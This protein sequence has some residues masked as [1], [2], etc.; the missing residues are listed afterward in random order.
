MNRDRRVARTRA[1]LIAAFDHLV[2]SRRG[3][4][5]RV[6]DIVE[7]ANVGR[8]TF[9]DHYSSADD[10]HMAALARPFATLADAAAGIGDAAALAPLLAHFWENRQRARQT[11]DGRTGEKTARMLAG[12]VAERLPD[13]N[14]LNIPRVLAAR[15]LG[16]A[17]LSP[18]HGWITAEAS[19]TPQ[20]LAD[21]ICRAGRALR[22]ALTAVNSDAPVTQ[23]T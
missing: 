6:A 7:K 9:Y 23:P 13:D 14:A 8:S 16:D 22:T 19:C 21:A 4:K 1:A 12:L 3:P 11:L 5:I 18:V 15:Q 2:L 20:A 17:A 10:I